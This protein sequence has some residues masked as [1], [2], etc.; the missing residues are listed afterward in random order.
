VIF[1]IIE[2]VHP[3]DFSALGK[4]AF[5]HALRLALN[6]QCKLSV[7]HVAESTI[8]EGKIVD[9]EISY[10]FL[11]R[12]ISQWRL[13]EELNSQFISAAAL[14]FQ[15]EHIALRGKQPLDTLTEYAH[16]HQ[17]QLIVLSTH[18]RTGLDHL[19][20]GSIAETLFSRTS[21]STLFISPHTRGFVDPVTAQVRLRR[22]LLP[23]D[24]SPTPDRA[25][26]A[27]RDFGRLLNGHEPILDLVHIGSTAPEIVDVR[28]TRPRVSLRPDYD[29]AKGIVEA[30]AE[31]TADMIC[32]ATAR[33]HGLLGALRGSTTRRVLHAAPCPVL[34]IAAEV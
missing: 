12:I 26:H 20:K 30:A 33:R 2:I 8:D 32:M 15:I 3:T 7:I 14:G 16:R 29:A 17:P 11:N 27:A 6:A 19:M 5:V 24:H 10:L 22:V 23:V 13:T 28:S 1:P 34:A 25:I 9:E 18:G 4:K 21:A 31:L